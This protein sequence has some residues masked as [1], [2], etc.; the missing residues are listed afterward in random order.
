PASPPISLPSI[1]LIESYQLVRQLGGALDFSAPVQGPLR[2][3]LRL[4]ASS[5]PTPEMLALPTTVSAAQPEL[6]PE[7]KSATTTPVATAVSGS[8]EQERR[9]SVRIPTT[10]P[11]TITVGSATWDGTI[12]NISFGGACITLP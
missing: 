7:T 10:L 1:D 9:S 2:I 6:A 3:I 12:S 8:R 11:A 5:P 4:P